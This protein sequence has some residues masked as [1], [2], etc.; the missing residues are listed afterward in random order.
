MTDPTPPRP[1]GNQ[2]DEKWYD[3]TLYQV[4][5]FAVG[6]ALFGLVLGLILDWYIDPRTS[7]AKK[8]LVQALGLITA[9][10]AG[11]VGIYFTWR[12]QRLTREAQEENQRNTLAQLQNAEKQLSLSQQSQEDNQRNTQEQLEQSRNELDITRRGQIT[13]RFTRAID[14]LGSESR[15]IKLGGIYS[16]ERTARE[17]RDYHWPIMEVLTT[18][19][20][21]HS[22]R[23]DEEKLEQGQA[24]TLD[25]EIQAILTVIGR[26]SGYHSDVEYGPIDLNGT[27]LRTAFL[28]E[29]NLENA[30]LQGANLH[31][32]NLQG[33]KLGGAYLRGAD[34]QGANLTGAD[35]G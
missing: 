33:A 6:I 7:T 9:G 31:G 15:E 8:D 28:L 12:S 5:L 2:E 34:L 25:P 4:L 35:L 26:R 29:A 19:V 3:K 21:T 23:K 1:R 14:Q 16:L 24:P 17:D 30:N 27:D 20:R 11:F 22:P 10:V 32:A 18:Y 13:E